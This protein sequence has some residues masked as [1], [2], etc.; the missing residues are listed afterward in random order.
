M[1]ILRVA[2]PHTPVAGSF[3]RQLDSPL[4]NDRSAAGQDEPHQGLIP[5]ARYGPRTKKLERAKSDRPCKI[6]LVD[7]GGCSRVNW[8]SLV[9]TLNKHLDHLFKFE[10]STLAVTELGKHD[11][12]HC[13]SD[14]RLFGILETRIARTDWAFA[15]GITHARLP[16][17]CF[18]RHNES[19][20]VGVV[21]VASAN[22]YL[23]PGRSL[24]QYLCYLVL[25]EAFCIVGGLQFEHDEQWYCLFDMCTENEDLFEC[26]Q[27]PK[28][29]KRCRDDLLD[30][31]FSEADLEEADRMLRYVGSTSPCRV[32]SQAVNNPA[33]MLVLGSLAG[34]VLR[35]LSGSP[36]PWVFS[37]VTL[38]LVLLALLFAWLNYE[39]IKRKPDGH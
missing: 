36:T 39:R 16:G 21:T 26:L 18:N 33:S 38:G 24:E 6:A 11:D 4:E 31:G 13:Y 20:G 17:H 28:I 12:G 3:M 22:R 30:S 5:R 29:Q 35:A 8:E 15:I 23:P 32:V 25:C 19:E 37:G 9:K 1:T 34:Y 7:L 14:E 2:S 10:H 27:D